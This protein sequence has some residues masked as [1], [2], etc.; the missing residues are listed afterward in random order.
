MHI[1]ELDKLIFIV[2]SSA[3]N[4]VVGLCILG[5]VVIFVVSG[6][7][8]GISK[9]QKNGNS[10]DVVSMCNETYQIKIGKQNVF[11]KISI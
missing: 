5:C 3:M 9:P 4:Q 11:I 7:N 8:I 6:S 2:S 1:K 10:S